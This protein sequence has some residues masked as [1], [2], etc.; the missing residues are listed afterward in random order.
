MNAIF[1]NLSQLRIVPVV[2]IRD[3]EDAA[4]LADALIRAESMSITFSGILIFH[5]NYLM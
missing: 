3:A 2:T 5:T 1:E 4:P